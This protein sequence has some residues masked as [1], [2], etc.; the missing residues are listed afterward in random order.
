MDAAVLPLSVK[1]PVVILLGGSLGACAGLWDLSSAALWGTLL[2]LG[3]SAFALS[4]AAPGLSLPAVIA[5]A[6]GV[7]VANLVA[8]QPP[9]IGL[10]PLPRGLISAAVAVLP[11]GI[12]ALAAALVLRVGLPRLGR[13]RGG[14]L[15]RQPDAPDRG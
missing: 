2:F 11:A 7:L 4:V 10:D 9:G 6:A 13:G 3:L 1:V 8:P 14:T 15:P 12:G 5:I